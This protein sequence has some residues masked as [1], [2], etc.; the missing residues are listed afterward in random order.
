MN[1]ACAINHHVP[2]L[3]GKNAETIVVI[4]YQVLLG[5]LINEAVDKSDLTERIPNYSIYVLVMDRCFNADKN[6]L[7]LGL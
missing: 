5:G 2:E 4:I 7:W 1:G 6:I 3:D